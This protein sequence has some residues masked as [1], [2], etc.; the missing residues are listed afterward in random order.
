MNNSR[1]NISR[2]WISLKSLKVLEYRR[3]MKTV[4]FLCIYHF[5][6]ECFCIL[7]YIY[8]PGFEVM[9]K[10]VAQAT[11]ILPREFKGCEFLV[12]LFCKHITYQI[13]SFSQSAVLFY[14]SSGL[15][16]LPYTEVTDDP[17]DHQWHGQFPHNGTWFLNTRGNFKDFPPGEGED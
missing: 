10:K 17:G 2:R 4:P 16:S 3:F 8:R 13:F 9:T 5:H 7:P 14:L 6:S 1:V 12:T 15:D 11:K